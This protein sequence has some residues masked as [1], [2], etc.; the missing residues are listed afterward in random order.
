M[1]R[2]ARAPVPEIIPIAGHWAE[3]TGA[4]SIPERQ[5]FGRSRGSSLS[6]MR[7]VGLSFLRATPCLVAVVLAMSATAEPAPSAPPTVGVIKLERRPMTDSYEFNGSIQS[8]TSDGGTRAQAQQ[9]SAKAVYT[10]GQFGAY[11]T[12]FC[13]AIVSVLE[14]GKFGGYACRPSAGTPDNISK[15]LASPTSIGLA[16]FDVF[17]RWSLDNSEVATSL[18]IVRTL[19]CEGLWMVAQDKDMGATSFAQIVDLSHHLKFAVAEGGSLASFEFL[20]KVD[21]KGI[22]QARNVAILKDATAVIDQVA[23]GNAAVGFF[24]QFADPSNANIKLLQERHL[25]TLPVVNPELVAARIGDTPV[26]HVKTFSL[27]EPGLFHGAN[28]VATACTP[29]V[30]ITGSPDMIGDRKAADDHRAMIDR[31]RAAPDAAFLPKGGYANLI[32]RV[33]SVTGPALNAMLGA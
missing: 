9:D 24:V 14:T 23:F 27:T 29:A 12:L 1:P 8:V 22:G 16:Q 21:P 5:T 26:Y 15:V 20:M 17:A 30:V 7:A 6:T 25:R 28:K 19:A 31:I 13:S 4:Y 2:S 11:H 3:T 18:V 33:T 32:A 10:A